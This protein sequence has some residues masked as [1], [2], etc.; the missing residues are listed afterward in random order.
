VCG[1]V[2][3]VSTKSPGQ[4][5][6]R[7]MVES[8]RSRGPDERS[9]AQGE[10]FAL[11]FC[12]LSILVLGE[13]GRQP[14]SSES[15]DIHLVFNGEIYNF[16][17]IQSQLRR[18]YGV[19]SVSEADALLQLYRRRGV[20]FAEQLEGD[21]SVVILDSRSQTCFAF[22]DPFGV[23]PLYYASIE[24]G[25]TWVLSSHIKAFF[26][27]PGFSTQLDSIA[28][29]ERRVVGFWSSHRTSFDG[30]HQLTPGHYLR[31]QIPPEPGSP[32]V[33]HEIV[34]FSSPQDLGT[35]GAG[36]VDATAIDVQCTQVIEEAVRKRIE[37]SDITPIVLALSGGIDSSVMASLARG[38][39]DRLAALTVFDSEECQDQEYSVQL[40]KGIGLRHQVY[41]IA[42]SEFLDEFPKIVLEMAGPNPSYTPYFLGRAMK[43][44]YPSAKVLLCGEGA[45][46]FFIGY[47]LLIDSA[48]Y[49]STCLST[50]RSFPAGRAA[51]SPVLRRI[52][53]WE[54]MQHEEICLSLIDMFQRE[55]LVNLHLVPFDHGTMA[56]GVECRVPF[57]DYGVIQFIQNVPPHLRVLGKTTK[58]LLRIL[59]SQM[60]GQ[61][62]ALTRSLLTRSS[63]PAWSSTLGCQRWLTAFLRRKMQTSKLA[64]SELVN[65][66]MDEQHLFWLASVTT[67][68]LKHRGRIDGMSF[69]DLSNEIFT[70]GGE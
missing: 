23:K 8:I 44:F 38:S 70:H 30:I 65:F 68:F 1:F 49:R 15:T 27:H 21:Y 48:H 11:G 54:S 13:G 37:H 59:L 34:Q 63:S 53:P 10:W 66:A 57:L 58:I 2:A 16:R 40:S 60:L 29:M 41:K 5:H 25:Q 35:P 33:E 22:R 28:L 42:L 4:R 17:S 43:Q 31:L 45:D 7:S 12:R 52:L 36:E 18:E 55:Q 9:C 24:N 6:L 46:E 62:S 50:L 69:A 3:L 26:H 56:H 47:P 64:H 19:A 51:E 14:V 39:R 61:G 67:I 20:S 32:K